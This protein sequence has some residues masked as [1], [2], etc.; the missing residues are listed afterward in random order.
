MDGFDED[1]ALD[2]LGTKY[3]TLLT[4]DASGG[5]VSVTDSVSPP[6]SGPPRHV[7]YDADETFVIITGEVGFWLNGQTVVCG[8]GSS[9]FIPR[10]R[11]IPFWF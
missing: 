8:P 4:R 11:R 3:R 2:W 1:G 6:Q 7:H 10:V 9:F 5:N